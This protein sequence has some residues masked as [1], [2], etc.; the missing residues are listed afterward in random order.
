VHA[1]PSPE[2]DH[3]GNQSSSAATPDRHRFDIPLAELEVRTSRSSGPGGQGVNT[4][5][6]KV[7]LR[8]DVARSPSLSA[9]QRARLLE[10]LGPRLT[11]DGVLILTGSEH[12]SQHRN[13]EAVLVRL[14]RIVTGALAETPPRQPTR[15]TR[16]SALRRLTAKRRH[17]SD[18]ALRR[19]PDDRD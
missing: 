3:P 5:D 19:R 2:S 4:T 11:A 14:A 18:K 7:E 8:W 10:R 12:R 13:R 15:P 17:A 9:A 1:D 16:G 6:S